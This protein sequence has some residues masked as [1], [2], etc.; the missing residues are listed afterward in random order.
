MGHF[1]PYGLR[2]ADGWPFGEGEGEGEGPAEGEGAAE[3][4]GEGPIEGIGEC[5]LSCMMSSDGATCCK[6]CGDCADI[7]MGSR[8][9]PECPEGYAWDCEMVCCFSYDSFTCAGVEI[10]ECA[11][12]CTSRPGAICCTGCGD[13]NDLP[14]DRQCQPSCSGSGLE[15]DCE[16]ECCLQTM[17]GSPYCVGPPR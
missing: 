3:G 15:W 9:Q 14:W 11:S 13:C 5:N 16:Q 2:F 12:A 10:G 7:P 6:G 17:E 4:E 8:C 1:T